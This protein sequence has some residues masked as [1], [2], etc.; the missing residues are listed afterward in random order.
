MLTASGAPPLTQSPHGG[1]H[2]PCGQGHMCALPLLW[3]VFPLPLRLTWLNPVF[4]TQL[5]SHFLL[6][7]FSNHSRSL[8]PPP[9]SL[10]GRSVAGGWPPCPRHAHCPAAVHICRASHKTVTFPVTVTFPGPACSQLRSPDTKHTG[11]NIT[12]P[13][14]EAVV[15]R[16]HR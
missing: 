7:T 8:P 10:P 15:T 6:R 11:K 9:T 16:T 1:P 5:K 4:E 12:F 3:M 13:R 14:S 2:P